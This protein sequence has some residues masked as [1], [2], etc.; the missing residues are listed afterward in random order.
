[1]ADDVEKLC[2]A[3][4]PLSPAHRRAAVE[5]QSALLAFE[6]TAE[7][8]CAQI[9]DAGMEREQAVFQALE[10]RASGASQASSTEQDPTMVLMRSYMSL[11]ALALQGKVRARPRLAIAEGRWRSSLLSAIQ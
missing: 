3:L 2:L 8:G 6:D 9:Y 1:M 10:E 11:A 7:K 5:L 4:I